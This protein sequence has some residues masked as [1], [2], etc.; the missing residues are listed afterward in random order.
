MHEN[1]EV[2]LE[3]QRLHDMIPMLASMGQLT[4]ALDCAYKKIKL[5]RSIEKQMLAQVNIEIP[6]GFRKTHLH[7]YFYLDTWCSDGVCRACYTSE[8]TEGNQ[9]TEKRGKRNVRKIW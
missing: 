6:T 1:E 8:K 7:L 4:G 2:R 9:G 3:I 5:L